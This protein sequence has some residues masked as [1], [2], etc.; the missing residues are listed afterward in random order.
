[1]QCTGVGGE[2]ERELL[3]EDVTGWRLLPD[4]HSIGDDACKEV[5]VGGE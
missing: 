4:V 2:V 3:M 5:S 1:M